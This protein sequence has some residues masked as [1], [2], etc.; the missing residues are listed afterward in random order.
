MCCVSQNTERSEAHSTKVVVL[1]WP[2]CFLSSK[3]SMKII[4]KGFFSS[5]ILVNTLKLPVVK[6]SGNLKML[7]LTVTKGDV[8]GGKMNKCVS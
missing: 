3:H 6:H 4:I 1:S 2:L 8:G 7:A 5:D